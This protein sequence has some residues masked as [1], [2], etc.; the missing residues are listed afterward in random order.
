MQLY[1]AMKLKKQGNT[2]FR[3]LSLIVA[4]LLGASLIV[5]N[6]E[7]KRLLRILG[8]GLMFVFFLSKLFESKADNDLSKEEGGE[9]PEKK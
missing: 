2:L 3:V 1:K 9:K 6:D 4:V 7:T 5:K 8:F